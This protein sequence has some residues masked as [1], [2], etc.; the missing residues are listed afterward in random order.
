[1]LLILAFKPDDQGMVTSTD[2]FMLVQPN[3]AQRSIFA[4]QKNGGNRGFNFVSQKD[5]F[6]ISSAKNGK[7]KQINFQTN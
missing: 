4:W 7:R 2:P 3:V 5:D 1:M 6:D